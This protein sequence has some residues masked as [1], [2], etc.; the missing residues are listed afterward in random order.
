[1]GVVYAARDRQLDRRAW[2][3]KSSTR[4]WPARLGRFANPLHHLVQ[5]SRPGVASGN[6]RDEGYLVALLVAFCDV[7]LALKWI[8]R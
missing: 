1:M 2:R 5:G 6:L 7:E 4:P 3:S 8:L